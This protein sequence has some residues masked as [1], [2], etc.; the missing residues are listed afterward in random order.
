MTVLGNPVQQELTV[1]VT[2]AA[3]QALRVQLTDAQG[4]QVF[5]RQVERAHAVERVVIPVG[6]QPTG[7]LVLRA[8]TATH[9]KAIKVLK[10]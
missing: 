10:Q 7:I 4:R 3:D 6:N 9:A 2:G 5:S 1:E 8:S